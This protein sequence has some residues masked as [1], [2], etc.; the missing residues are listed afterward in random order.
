MNCQNFENILD[1]LSRNAL[2]DARSR[3]AA[4]AHADSC[5][6]CA[7]RLAD[8]KALRAGLRSLAA[9]ANG[10]EAP[11]RVEA[12]LLAAFRTQ[13]GANANE[14][15]SAPAAA[16]GNVIPL[17]RPAADKRWNWVRTLGTAATAA[18]AA[19]VLLMIIPPGVDT[20][21]TPGQGQES[22]QVSKM[23]E[24]VPG[25]KRDEEVA[26]TTPEEVADVVQ[27]RAFNSPRGGARMTQASYSPSA[28]RRPQATS[29]GSRGA[30]ADREVVTEFIPL[31]QGD[32]YSASVD[33]GQV[34]RV[35]LPRSAL[36]SIGMP[37]SADRAGERI[38]ADVL[39]GED[40]VARAIRFV[41]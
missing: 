10:R 30:K 11:P 9:S 6:R 40:G 5:T 15:T 34:L 13:A 1:D 8:E 14:N 2:M 27:P 16:E 22:P 20:P 35:E 25:L 12:A 24:P 23:I 4:L 3:E 29:A 33:A 41:R 39:V 32:Y 37:V 36:S 7:S 26:P 31:G 38:K 17:K 28:G 21:S 19:A 18:A